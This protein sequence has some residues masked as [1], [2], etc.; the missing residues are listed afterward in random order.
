MFVSLHVHGVITDY[1]LCYITHSQEHLSHPNL[2]K[3]GTLLHLMY[4]VFIN[5]LQSNTVCYSIL[6]KGQVALS[7]LLPP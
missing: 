5:P 2:W 7:I 3:L 4:G 6:Y 1:S